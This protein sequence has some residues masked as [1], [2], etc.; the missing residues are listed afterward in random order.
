MDAGQARREDQLLGREDSPLQIVGLGRRHDAAT[1]P[2]AP[3]MKTPVGWPSWSRRIW[4]SEGALVSLVDSGPAHGLGVGPAGVAVDPVQPDRPVGRDG[5]EH[6]G[7]GEG[8]AGPEALV[9]VP[10]VIHESPGGVDP[11]LDPPGDLVERAD[12]AQVDLLVAGPERFDVA[13]GVDQA[14]HG[15]RPGRSI[16]MVRGSL[17]RKTSSPAADRDDRAVAGARASAQGFA[18]RRSRSAPP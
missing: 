13:V 17:N 5:V 9:P 7:G 6:G 12:P 4:P 18:G 16:T 1:R 2:I 14:G 3:S 11:R 15:E 10:P 8:A